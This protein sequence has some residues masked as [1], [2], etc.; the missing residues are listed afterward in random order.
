MSP[1]EEKGQVFIRE[2][3]GRAARQG[4]LATGKGADM[5]PR[6]Y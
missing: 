2:R 4:E 3:L 6:D 5:S 1:R